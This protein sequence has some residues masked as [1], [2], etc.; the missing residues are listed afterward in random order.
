[1][2]TTE[3]IVIIGGLVFGYWIVAGLFNRKSASSTNTHSSDGSGDGA[4]RDRSQ[5][6]A[7]GNK[8]P[9]ENDYIPASWFRILEVSESASR[10]QIVTAYKQKIRQYHPDKVAQMGAEIRELAEFKSKQI[11][12]AYDYAIN[13]R[14]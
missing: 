2:T 11:N 6:E 13:L 14:R 7:P 5:N 3:V 1:M 12:T 4:Q 10:E 9:S 8:S